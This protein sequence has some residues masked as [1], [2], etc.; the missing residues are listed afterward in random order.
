MMCR[1]L[2]VII[3]A[4]ML[5][6]DG[7]C[8]NIFVVLRDVP[9]SPSVV[10]VPSGYGSDETELADKAEEMLM[11]FRI[12][13]VQRPSLRRVTETKG[14]AK[15]TAG[16]EGNALG[17]EGMTEEYIAYEETGAD[18]LLLTDEKTRR[19]K[20]VKIKSK[21]ILASAKAL[22]LYENPCYDAFNEKGEELGFK[23]AP[24]F[25]LFNMLKSVGLPVKWSIGTKK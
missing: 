8:Q 25:C 5:K 22:A 20:L 24:E 3:A 14:A 13:V 19:V 17:S 9:E 10:V 1:I 23:S 4:A 6:Y 15:A 21:E 12:K 18:Y 11:S 16:D 7:L 2:F